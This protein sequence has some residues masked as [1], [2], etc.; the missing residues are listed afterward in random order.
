M[1]D[2]LLQ[3]LPAS[4]IIINKADLRSL[5]SLSLN[6]SHQNL[7]HIMRFIAI[8]ILALS[9]SVASSQQF[10]GHPP[11]VKWKQ[12]NTDTSRV[13]FPSGLDSQAK[14]IAALL[15]V[16]DRYT[17]VSIGNSHRKINIVLQPAT[18]ISNAY[19]GLGPFR[20][21]FQ[22]TPRLNSFE[23]GSLPWVDNLAIHEYRHVQQYNNFNR[24]ISK[25][26]RFVFGEEG[27][28]LA[29]ALVVPDWFFEGDAVYQETQVSPQGRGRLPYFFNDYRS[30]WLEGKDYSWMKLRNGSLRDFVPDHY[31]LGYLLTA[32]G[33]ETYGPEFWKKVSSDAAAFKGLLYPWQQAVKRHAGISYKQFREDAM[34]YFH[35]HARGDAAFNHPGRK[36]RHFVADEEYP[37]WMDSSRI[38]YLETSYKKLPRFV[39]RENDQVTKLRTRDITIDNYFSYRNCKIVYA[40]YRADTR[41]RWRDYSDLK[42]LDVTTGK[43]QTLTTRTKYFT[44]DISSDSKSVA[45]VHVDERGNSILHLLNA[46]N[47]NVERIIPNKDGFFFTYPKF[48]KE[49]QLVSAVRDKEGKMSLGITDLQTG[50]TR[51]VLPFTWNVI[52]F[53][54]V[55]GDTVYFTASSGRTDK[56]FAWTANGLFL[57]EGRTHETGNYQLNA[58]NGKYAWTTFTATGFRL[59]QGR[60]E[61]LYDGPNVLEPN[62]SFNVSSVDKEPG[63]LLSQTRNAQYPVTDYSQSFRLFN[64]H[65]RRPYISD[66]DYS[67]SFVSENILN[68]LQSELSFNYNRNEGYK[69]LGFA[70]IY[71]GL[72]PMIRAGVNYTIDRNA[73]ATATRSAFWNEAE[74]RLGLLVPLNFTSGRNFTNLS[75]GTDYVYN[76]RQ[77]KGY[78]KDSFENRGFGYINSTINFSRQVQQ[79]RMHIYPRFAQT[80]LVNYKRAVTSLQGNQF[81]ASGSIYLPGV[82][83]TH[84]LV[85]QAAFQRRDTVGD[86]SFSN[87]FPFS[88]GYAGDN[89]RQMWKLGANYHF[90]LI[91]PD[92]GFANLVYFLRVRANVFYDYTKIDGKYLFMY[93]TDRVIVGPEFRSYGTEIFFDTK[94]WNQL[95][96]SFGFRFSRLMDPDSER[97]GANQWEFV[98]P[99]NLL[100]R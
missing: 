1:I 99:V 12:V 92:W 58:R 11:S 59:M 94:W 39:I 8:A 57:A 66:P 32:Y 16:L 42:L 86:V 85:I 18:T 72:F 93:G 19:V 10:G 100:T 98:L 62:S 5:S 74:G 41:W 43:Q 81:L 96:V 78:F 71:G 25:A 23:L 33:Y 24:G 50:D 17:S 69:Q 7:L 30:L 67:F 44:P 15:P 60:R 20:S 29:N 46:T 56:L 34:D 77:F 26:F 22:L 48:Y 38:I 97:R 2:G 27:Q 95:P 75:L 65:S 36:A 68:T 49:Q 84:N 47:G 40:A 63:D 35:S 4:G 9:W 83:Q 14:R 61:D 13:I 51:Y 45:A 54:W 70:A 3:K 88:R 91:Y 79:A 53:P 64:F 80:L 21:E 37:Y 73:R 31:R 52:G 55:E 82:A 28:A 87:G 76:K 90:P 6:L 89:F